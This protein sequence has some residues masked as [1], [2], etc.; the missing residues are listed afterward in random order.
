MSVEVLQDELV[1]G[2]ELKIG[3]CRE[4]L[5]LTFALC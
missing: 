1:L 3:H 5:K 4:F 2:T